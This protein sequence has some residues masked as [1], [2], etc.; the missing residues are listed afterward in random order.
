MTEIKW[1]LEAMAMLFLR[2]SNKD[3]KKIFMAIA[4]YDNTEILSSGFGFS[5]LKSYG[6]VTIINC[7]LTFFKFY[8]WPLFF[9]FF[10]KSMFFIFVSRLSW[11]I[12][13]CDS[14]KSNV[15][16]LSSNFNP[17]RWAVKTK[18]CFH[19]IFLC[20]NAPITWCCHWNIWNSS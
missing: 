14:S 7:K 18:D 20:K 10:S 11:K 13:V 4:T 15:E 19:F 6:F 1:I 5:F 16:T 9:I 3:F 2:Q 8:W 12:K 17:R